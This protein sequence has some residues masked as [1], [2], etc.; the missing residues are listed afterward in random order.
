MNDKKLIGLTGLYCAGKNHVALLLEQRGLPVLDVDKLGYKVIEM[1]RE[2][3]LARFGREILGASGSIDRKRLGAK[4]FGKPAELAAL[5]NIIHPRVNSET[6]EWIK[7]RGEKACV[8]NA[9]LLHRSSAFTLLD[10]IILVEAPVLIRLFR[11][12]KRDHLPWRALVKRFKSQS[13]FGTQ[14]F[15][16]KTDIYRVENSGCFGFGR[17]SRRAKL[18]NRINEILSREGIT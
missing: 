10:A 4:V 9:A 3:L 17:D 5:E 13:T 7:S 14:Y 1:E 8:I 12:K 15:S 16:G 11:A 18:E 6:I 2:T